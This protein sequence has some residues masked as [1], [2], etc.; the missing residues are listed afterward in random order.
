MGRS[1]KPTAAD[2]KK[3]RLVKMIQEVTSSGISKDTWNPAEISEGLKNINFIRRLVDTWNPAQLNEAIRR[4]G[5]KTIDTWNPA[6]IDEMKSALIRIFALHS[7]TG[8]PII[9]NLTGELPYLIKEATVTFSPKQSGTGDPSPTNIRP[10]SGWDGLNLTRTGKNLF[11]IET[12]TTKR[13]VN[14]SGGLSV[15]DGW[16]A[17]DYIPIIGNTN[18]VISGISNTG[19]VAQHAFYDSTKTFISSINPTV[20]SFT[21]P[22]NARYIRISMRSENPTS[23][24]V[25]YGQTATAFVPYET[26][27]THTATFPDTVYGGTYD[28]VSGKGG[29]VWKKYLINDLTL[30]YSSSGQL[31]TSTEIPELLAP[32]SSREM[33]D[34]NMCEFLKNHEV[35]GLESGQFAITTDGRI[36]IKIDGYTTEE[37]LKTDFGTNKL[38]L[39]IAT[40]THIELTEQKIEPLP[41]VNVFSTDADTLNIKYQIDLS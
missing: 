26:P 38:T 17:S 5:F 8:N 30:T 4:L 1:K 15:S 41:G 37:D 7:V 14:G 3:I 40:P 9:L 23:V 34:G 6:I 28:F 12:I 19:T 29:E 16:S 11:D 27:E 32:A 13:Y 10:I 20:M 24:Q 35:T 39:K 21:T 18:I 36:R 22:A 31:F 2:M 25:E 33:I